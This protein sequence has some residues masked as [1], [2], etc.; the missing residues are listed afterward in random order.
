MNKF[1]TSAYSNMS[2]ADKES[3]FKTVFLNDDSD[4]ALKIRMEYY[5]KVLKHMGKNVYIGKGV[6]IVN[7]QYIRM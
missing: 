1:F 4:Y 5:G 7:P 6:K 2:E 3:F